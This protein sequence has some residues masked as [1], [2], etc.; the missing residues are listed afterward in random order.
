MIAATGAPDVLA[1]DKQDAE[2]GAAIPITVVSN[3]SPGTKVSHTPHNSVSEVCMRPTF[4]E[5]QACGDISIISSYNCLQDKKL[6]HDPVQVTLAHDDDQQIPS[7]PP[8]NKRSN[9]V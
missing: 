2:H 7:H 4:Y 9:Q 8:G 5:N 1:N 3:G 6:L